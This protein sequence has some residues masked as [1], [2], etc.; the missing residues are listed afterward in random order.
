MG[1]TTEKLEKI[2]VSKNTIKVA[3]QNKGQPITD[4]TP[5][6]EYATFI[7]NIETGID[8][9]DA[10]AT[11]ADIL[12]GKTAYVN[13][14]KV[15]GS[16]VAYEGAFVENVAPEYE[17]KFT[18]WLNNTLTEVSD[19]TITEI[20]D[21]AF[22]NKT[23]LVS[24]DFPNATTIG[25]YAFYNCSNINE[26]NL[27]DV[28]IIGMYA[29][30]NN[31]RVEKFY[32]NPKANITSLSDSCFYNFGKLRENEEYFVFDLRNSSFSS[33]DSSA[34]YSNKNTQMFLPKSVTKIESNAFSYNE[35]LELYLSSLPSLSSTN[36]FSNNTNL[37]I[38]SLLDDLGKIKTLT[39]WSNYASNIFGYDL[40]TNY[41]VGDTLPSYT[42]EGG[43]AITWYSDKDLTIELTNLS[44]NE[45][46]KDSIFYA[47]T[48]SER[49]VG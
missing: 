18:A 6:S 43:F 44:I 21:Y 29:F 41:Q 34:F 9:T 20:P 47:S 37:K 38:F 32:L 7:D 17:D 10:T 40:G 49:A 45:S 27:K 19:S 22:Y 26:I 30:N 5:L 12:N 14:E 3:I 8:T 42:N 25:S 15:T 1:T 11:S 33:V 16:I 46:N 13:D 35:N 31:T 24:A 39:N 48:S 2:L 36:V 23:N 4:T 28:S